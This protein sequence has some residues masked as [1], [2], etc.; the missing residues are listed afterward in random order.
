[1]PV[2]YPR[3]VAD[4]SSRI[5]VHR[6]T[7]DADRPGRT[8]EELEG[9]TFKDAQGKAQSAAIQGDWMHS[10]QMTPTGFEPV[11]RP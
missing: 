10:E 11:S 5:S 6:Q 7:V 8:A 2:D 3:R 4:A 1:M 9:K